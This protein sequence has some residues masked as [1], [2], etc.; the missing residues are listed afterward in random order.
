MGLGIGKRN[1]FGSR[2]RWNIRSANKDVSP[3]EKRR[4]QKKHTKTNTTLED[5]RPWW[6]TKVGKR[7]AV[8][9]EGRAPG[10]R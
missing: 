6:R 7:K 9:A 10:C 1:P 4:A 3:R 2:W 8:S 5:G